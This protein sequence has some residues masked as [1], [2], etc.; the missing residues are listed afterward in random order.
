MQR[1]R[2]IHTAVMA[3]FVAMLLMSSSLGVEGRLLRGAQTMASGDQ[4]L[5]LGKGLAMGSAS[6]SL[7]KEY[8]KDRDNAES[9]RDLPAARKVPTFSARGGSQSYGYASTM[10]ATK[11]N[12]PIM[13]SWMSGG[14]GGNVRASSFGGAS[15]YGSSF[16]AAG[17]GSFGGMRGL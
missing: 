6:R 13:D 14:G 4:L 10:P 16:G 11:M 9:Y 8:K 5:A 2:S 3:M 12:G 17:Y 1:L 15:A 7:L